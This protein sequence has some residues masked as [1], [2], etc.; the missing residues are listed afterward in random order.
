[1]WEIQGSAQMLR[2]VFLGLVLLLFA[3]FAAGIVNNNCCSKPVETDNI[4]KANDRA[5]KWLVNNK[6]TLIVKYS[7]N[8]ILW[9]MI[10][11]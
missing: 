9:W 5:I 3:F 11:R 2:R 6:E 1:M 8:G 10:K 4:R 7:K